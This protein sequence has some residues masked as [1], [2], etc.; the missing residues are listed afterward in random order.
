MTDRI[1]RRA[2]L[3][4]GAG[5]GVAVRGFDDRHAI[6]LS[7]GRRSSISPIRSI[8]TVMSCRSI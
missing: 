3:A 5:A 8:P 6:K 7:T 2:L 4:S 1:T